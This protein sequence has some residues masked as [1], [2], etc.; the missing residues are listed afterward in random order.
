LAVVW[1]NFVLR[2]FQIRLRQNLLLRSGFFIDDLTPFEDH[3]SW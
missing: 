1:V 2:S 3:F